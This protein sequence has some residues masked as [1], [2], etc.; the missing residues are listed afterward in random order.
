M[1]FIKKIIEKVKKLIKWIWSECK[2]WRTL[3]IFIIV[4]C[5]VM[6]PV[7]VGYTLYFVTKN[8]WHLTYASVWLLFWFGPFTPLIPICIAVSFGVKKLLKI[9]KKHKEEKQAKEEDEKNQ[10]N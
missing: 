1:N 8:E 3:V 6:S 5:V 4:Y 2:D 10:L 7:I 9:K